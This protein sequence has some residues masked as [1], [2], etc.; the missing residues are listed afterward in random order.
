M[1][2]IP[3]IESIENTISQ[4]RINE[5]TDEFF[6][7]FRHQWRE[8]TFPLKQIYLDQVL[9]TDFF[10]S[11]EVYKHIE[12]Q[13]YRELAEKVFTLL[14]W[15]VQHLCREKNSI[16]LSIMVNQFI[17]AP[18]INLHGRPSAV[19]INQDRP[20][21][22]LIQTYNIDYLNLAYFI[23][24]QACVYARILETM[25]INAQHLLYVNY[26][27]MSLISR[28]LTPND[29]EKLDT[30]LDTFQVSLEEGS[31]EPPSTPPCKICEFM[32][33]CNS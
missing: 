6:S 2:L 26:R 23:P 12:D 20:S 4:E 31:F 33:I 21:L 25:G 15:L 27:T 30:F 24:L 32:A 13:I 7:V 22:I 29:F 17:Q 9:S 14:T 10:T 19:F 18:E 8:G 28:E 3:H 11:L 16:T 1:S 5:F